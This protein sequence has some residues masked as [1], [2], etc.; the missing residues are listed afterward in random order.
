MRLYYIMKEKRRMLMNAQEVLDFWFKE[1]EDGD[2]FKKDEQLDETIR[3]RF[4]ETH[5]QVARGETYQWRETIQGRLAEIIVLD[6]FSRNMF[7]GTP[8][9]F[10]YDGQAL[11]LSQEAINTGQVE[12]L[13][14]LEQAFLYMPLMHS[15]SVVIHEVAMTLFSKPGMETFFDFEKQ[16]F[17]I[18]KKY[19]RYPHRND[20]L[21][22]QTTPEEALFLTQ[23]GSSF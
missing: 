19:G 7:R 1:L 20:L 16:H 13:S 18:I 4:L 14:I 15:E 8:E 12:Q 9:T 23:P 22:R 2:R 5:G 11:V 6:Q 10:S 17:D 21:G 3:A